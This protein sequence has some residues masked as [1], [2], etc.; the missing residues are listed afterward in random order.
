M[1]WNRN[2]P[3]TVRPFFG[4]ADIEGLLKD[5]HLVIGNSEA[6]LEGDHVSIDPQD[7]EAPFSI[8]LAL[9]KSLLARTLGDDLEKVRLTVSLR[10][11]ML[12]RR[13]IVHEYRLSDEVPDV[14][15][16]PEPDVLDYSHRRE[17]QIRVFLAIDDDIS[18]DRPGFP[19]FAGQWL[20][21]RVFSLKS[22]DVLGAFRIDPMTPD[23][24]LQHTGFSGALS[25]VAYRGGMLEEA[26]IDAPVA[27]C[28]VAENVFRAAEKS[29]NGRLTQFLMSELVFGVLWEAREEVNMAS[30][31]AEGTPLASLLGQLSVEKSFTLEDLKKI[32]DDPI[33]LRAVIQDRVSIVEILGEFK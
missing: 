12:K 27:D 21:R 31:A 3:K 7:F 23:E 29:N 22:P 6:S 28:L 14:L 11:P 15:S 20:D 13:L 1:S 26:N 9:D 2:E 17:L 4:I 5:S 8:H 24:A 25:H 10:D 16:L 32:I 18:D 19:K 33:Q 30:E